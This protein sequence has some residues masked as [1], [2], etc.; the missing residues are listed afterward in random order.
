MKNY[1]KCKE[2]SYLMYSDAN[3][4][5]GWE[6]S[7]KLSLDNFKWKK[8][9]SDFDEKFTKSSDENSDKVYIPEVDAE[10]PKELHKLQNDLPFLPERMK[11]KKCHKLLSNM[12]DKKSLFHT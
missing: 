10:Y 4:L 8:N 6:M 11:I 1:N 7:Q 5:Y 3:N 2:S 9:T 12:Y